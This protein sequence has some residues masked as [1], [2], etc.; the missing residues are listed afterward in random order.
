MAPQSSNGSS[1]EQRLAEEDRERFFTLS[2]DMLCI[3]G[4]DGYFKRVNPAW[5]PTLGYTTEEL[6]AEPFLSF[7]HPDDRERTAS[8]AAKLGTG[9]ETIRFEERYRRQGATYRWT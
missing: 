2:L 9:M 8:E 6:L 4:F 5:E 3:A 7:V 1:T